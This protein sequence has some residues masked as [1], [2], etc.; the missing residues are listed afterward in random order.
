MNCFVTCNLRSKRR[1]KL[2]FG[3][4]HGFPDNPRLRVERTMECEDEASVEFLQVSLSEVVYNTTTPTFKKVAL[5]LQHLCNGN[6][7]LPLKWSI[8]SQ[9][10]EEKRILYGEISHSLDDIQRNQGKNLELRNEKGKP[11]GFIKFTDFK[12][13]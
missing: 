1:T 6:R 11:Q 9:V 10:N 4:F 12:V 13:I 7:S 5:K 8:Y 2:T 3:C